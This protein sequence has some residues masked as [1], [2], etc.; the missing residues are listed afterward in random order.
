MLTK[1]SLSD[2]FKRGLEH[3]HHAR[4]ISITFVVVLVACMYLRVELASVC[5]G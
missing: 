1:V 5:N 2:Y 4:E 3:P